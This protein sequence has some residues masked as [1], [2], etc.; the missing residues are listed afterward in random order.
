[1]NNENTYFDKVGVYLDNELKGEELASFENE[2]NN[3]PELAKELS[4]QNELIQ[5]IHAYRKTQLINRLDSIQVG[6]GISTGLI[7][8]Y[9]A[10]IAVIGGIGFGVYSILPDPVPEKELPNL[11]IEAESEEN[12]INELALEELE[13]TEA[14]NQGIED[15]KNSSQISEP[16]HE[17][18]KKVTSESDIN[19]VVPLVPN[20]VQDIEITEGEDELEVPKNSI[21]STEKVE[22]TT[23]EV[24]I[25][26][27]VKKYK[28]HYK[29]DN[30]KLVLYGNFDEEPYQILEIN[31]NN[32]TQVYLF[33]KSKYYSIDRQM[34]SITPLVEIINKTIIEKLDKIKN[35][36]SQG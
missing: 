12:Q 27:N 22:K 31:V 25:I 33:F 9:I 26:S 34:D 30:G 18:V 5:G 14:N 3:N 2:L 17:P 1:M 16:Q 8:K 35:S 36:D 13:E 19:P 28:F 11:V 32:E 20:P 23:P 15:S 7:A 29:V 24:E 4:F 6:T 10:G 21:G